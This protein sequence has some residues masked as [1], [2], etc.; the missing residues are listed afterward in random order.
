[1]KLEEVTKSTVDYVRTLTRSVNA[2]TLGNRARVED[3][4]ERMLLLLECG[5][6]LSGMVKE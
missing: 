2:R 5:H 1:M 6:S 4:L 3:L